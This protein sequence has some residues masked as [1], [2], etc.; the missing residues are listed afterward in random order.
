MTDPQR[1]KTAFL[2]SKGNQL[3]SGNIEVFHPL[4]KKSDTKMLAIRCD[5]RKHELALRK[6]RTQGSKHL[7]E[8]WVSRRSAHDRERGR[9]RWKLVNY[10]NYCILTASIVHHLSAAVSFFSCSFCKKRKKKK[11]SYVRHMCKNDNIN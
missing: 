9:R 7:H 3:D 1:S 11:L 2:D 6:Q 10:T 8:E 5:N 4:L